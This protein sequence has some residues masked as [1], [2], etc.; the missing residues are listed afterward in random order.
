MRIGLIDKEKVGVK[1]I[2][3][4]VAIES[5]KTLIDFCTQ[6]KG[7]QNC[8]FREF[9]ADHWDCHIEAWHLQEAIGNMEAKKK[10]HGYI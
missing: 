4:K 5:A 3:D 1:K 2:Y 8:I 7:C 9:G 6:Q 10:H